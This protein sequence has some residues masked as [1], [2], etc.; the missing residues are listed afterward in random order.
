MVTAARTAVR[1]GAVSLPAIGAAALIAVDLPRPANDTAEGKRVLFTFAGV[2]IGL[3]V[4]FI[5]D[6]MQQ[7]SAKATLKPA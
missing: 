5:A 6:R 3:V 1:F 7:H 4:M 2:G